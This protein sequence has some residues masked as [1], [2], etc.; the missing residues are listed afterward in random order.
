[1]HLLMFQEVFLVPSAHA[2]HLVPGGIFR[3]ICAAIPLCSRSHYPYHLL[4]H[5]PLY[6]EVFLFHTLL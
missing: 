2:F 5:F 3:T 4:M 1:M 6:H